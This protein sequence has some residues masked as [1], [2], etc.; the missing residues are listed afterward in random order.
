MS[1][2][3]SRI[4]V[5]DLC[6]VHTLH[7]IFAI[8]LL[9]LITLLQPEKKLFTIIPIWT[10]PGYNQKHII[11][12]YLGPWYNKAATI[13]SRVGVLI[14]L[15]RSRLL[16]KPIYFSWQVEN[17]FFFQ[18]IKRWEKNTVLFSHCW[19]IL[20]KNWKVP[21]PPKK[22]NMVAKKEYVRLLHSTGKIF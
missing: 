22:N 9:H 3:W 4:F 8:I 2:F 5:V 6:L 17:I 13:W 21:L 18:H 16:R 12:V 20:K 19:Y 10:Y 1:C 15:K 11:L 14:F 7:L